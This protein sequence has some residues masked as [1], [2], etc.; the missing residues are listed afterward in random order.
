MELD[1]QTKNVILEWAGKIVPAPLK[2][3]GLFLADPIRHWRLQNQLNFLSK[4]KEKCANKNI[5]LKVIAPKIVYSLLELSSLEDDEYM[6]DK[7]A[8]M[9][10]NM[11]DPEQNF[12][13][14]IL[15]FILS[16]ISKQE[17]QS[18]YK[19]YEKMLPEL[20][21]LELEY[22]ENDK[23]LDLIRSKYSTLFDEARITQDNVKQQ[24]LRDKLKDETKELR[25]MNQDIEMSIDEVKKIYEDDL[26]ELEMANLLRLG[27]ITSFPESEANGRIY[28]DGTPDIYVTNTGFYY[29]LSQLGELFMES[30]K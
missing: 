11:L 17:F 14:H 21:K 5:P 12:Q 25:L 26:Q 30:C 27:L 18:L 4:T 7:W 2:E 20:R 24:L 1:D 9:F 23:G 3:I 28:E 13:N 29:E 16:Q 6:Q 19:H 8:N 15:P 10:A 22:E